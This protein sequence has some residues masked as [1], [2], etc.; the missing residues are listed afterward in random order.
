MWSNRTVV[1]RRGS[2]L[3]MVSLLLV[4]LCGF[5]ALSVEIA[6]I[7][8]VKVQCQNAADT[9][10]MAGARTLNGNASQN[11]S[12]AQAMVL[13]AAASNTALGLNSSGKAA[14]VPFASKEVSSTI[15]TYR[16]NSSNQMFTPAYT[17]VAGENYNL[18]QTTVQRAV[19]NAFFSVVGGVNAPADTTTV[20]ASS[21][22]AHRP[23]DVAILLDF[24][25]SMNVESDLW[26]CETYLGSYNAQ[27]NNPDPI[28]P[29]FG[30]YSD[31]V[32]AA[33]V[34]TSGSPGGSSN[35][36]ASNMGMP[37]MA[38]SY[39]QTSAA[40]LPSVAA[41]TAAPN[42]YATTPSGDLPITKSD[43]ANG[44]NYATNL[45]D[46]FGTNYTTSYPTSGIWS[47]NS[48]ENGYDGYVGYD[49]FY[50][51]Q[52]RL[53][54]HTAGAERAQRLGQPGVRGLHRRTGLLGQNLLPLATRPSAQQRLAT[55]LLHRREQQSGHRQ[56][57]PL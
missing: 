35:I 53:L 52:H 50:F 44:S 48:F 14:L 18:V 32:D 16:Y 36:T 8:L 3:P 27:S 4:A 26:N 9:S 33:L 11:Y 41:F 37:V 47:P 21:V 25:G 51:G 40:T 42:S 19:K 5:T 24:S 7:A 22:A 13:T 31:A 56:Y 17:L 23:R 30:H 34:S 12:Q 55:T 29:T 54:Q 46:I 43:T 15:G 45:N 20:V 10:A 2:V 28:I 57:G 6:T 38:N 49:F 39:F 1:R